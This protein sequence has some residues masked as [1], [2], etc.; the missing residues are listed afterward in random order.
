[1]PSIELEDETVDRLDVLHIEDESDDELI[2]IYE[3]SELTL[4]RAGD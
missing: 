2:N 3:A 1:M 4:H